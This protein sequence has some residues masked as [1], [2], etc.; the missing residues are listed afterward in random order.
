MVASPPAAESGLDFS[1]GQIWTQNGGSYDDIGGIYFPNA[2]SEGHQHVF[3]GKQVGTGG[4]PISSAKF[5]NHTDAQTLTIQAC[6][7]RVMDPDTGAIAHG[8]I[9]SDIVIAAGDDYEITTGDMWWDRVDTGFTNTS[10]D[11]KR[12]AAGPYI[13]VVDFSVTWS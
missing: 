5:F 4:H 8:E 6:R 3:V 12:T 13:Q 10:G 2:D 1:A 11:P 7:M 9:G